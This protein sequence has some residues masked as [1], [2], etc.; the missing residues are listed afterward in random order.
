MFDK[1]G[2]EIDAVMIATP[3]HA[4]F[5]D[6]DVRDPARQAR[7]RRETALPH[8]QR[9]APPDRGGRQEPEDR[10][11]NG[12]PGAF[13]RQRRPDQRLGG[14]RSDR[15]GPRGPSPTRGRT[16]GPTSRSIQ[17]SVV[18]DDLDWNLYLNR[19]EEIPFSESYMNRE[20]I[21]YSHFSGSVGDMGGHTLD[22]GFYALGLD[23]TDQRPRRGRDAGHR[24][25]DAAGRRHH[26]GVPRPRRASRRSP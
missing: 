8:H 12:Q 18:P 14:G 2:N 9:G 19:A 4:R 22:A 16:T 20:W 13:D 6:C 25:V 15:P 10:H 21:R 17:G 3:D 5:A 11:P 23:R 26:L 24:L 1:I 7:L